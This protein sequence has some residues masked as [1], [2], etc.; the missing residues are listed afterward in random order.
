MKLINSNLLFLILSL[1]LLVE[2]KKP[3]PIYFG[4]LSGRV[5]DDANQELGIKCN[6]ILQPSGLSSTTDEN[7]Y[8]KFENLDPKDDFEVVVIFDGYN[9]FTEKITITSNQNTEL[10]V[11][12][13]S[14]PKLT[15]SS[16][17]VNEVISVGNTKSLTWSFNK[18]ENLKIEL[19]KADILVLT[20]ANTTDN[21]GIFEWTIPLNT[22]L[23]SGNDYKIKITSLVSSISVTSPLFTISL[24]EIKIST[25]A[26]TTIGN[27]LTI[28]WKYEITDDVK[29][30]LITGSNT[31]YLVVDRINNQ[32]TYNWKISLDKNIP[33]GPNNYIKIT[34]LNNPAISATSPLFTLALPEIKISSI[35]NSILGNNLKINWEYAMSDYVKIELVTGENTNFLIVDRMSNQLTH[36]WS[37][38]IDKNIPVGSGNYIKITSLSNPQIS[39]TSALFTLA[40][41]E[42]K[43]ASVS[44]TTLG[45]NVNISWNYDLSE[46]VKIELITGNNTTFVVA[47]RISNSKSYL[48]KIPLDKNLPSGGNN[49]FKIT[50]LSNTKIV[51]TSALFQIT[52]PTITI[53]SPVS[54]DVYLVESSKRIQWQY[55]N[56]EK[57]K[58]EL[59]HDTTFVSTISNE[60]DNLGEYLWKIPL[61]QKLPTSHLYRIK[62]SS[63]LDPKIFSI[64]PNF[65]IE[66]PQITINSPYANTVWDLGGTYNVT[67][68]YTPLDQLKV[69]LLSPTSTIVS[70]IVENNGTT[71]ISIPFPLGVPD[72]NNFSVKITSQTD[73]RIS[74]IINGITLKSPQISITSPVNAE[75]WNTD[76]EYNVSWQY[77]VNENVKIELLKGSTLV[78]VLAATIQNSGNTKV[79][80][81]YQTGFVAAN[82]Y[83][84]R[85]A[86]ITHPEIAS[87]SAPF[88]INVPQ[89]S[90]LSPVSNGNVIVGTNQ[91]ISWNY[92]SSNNVKIDLY[93]GGVWKKTITTSTPNTGSF[94]WAV[95]KDLQLLP[96][97]D[98]KI[99]ITN[100]NFT[101]IYAESSNFN[102]SILP[103]SASFTQN[104]KFARIIDEITFTNTSTNAHSYEWS[105]SAGHTSTLTSP[106]FTFNSIGTYTITLKS[107]TYD[108]QESVYQ[109]NI[110]IGNVY[111]TKITLTSIEWQIYGT[112]WD[113]VFGNCDGPDLKLYFGRAS[114]T[115]YEYSTGEWSNAVSNDITGGGVFPTFAT[116]LK[117]NNE[118]WK[119][120][121][122]DIDGIG[123]E[124]MFMLSA[125]FYNL[126]TFDA[127]TG[128]GTANFYL[129]ANNNYKWRMEYEILNQ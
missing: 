123:S 77:A 56:Y 5:V 63:T 68:T 22:S 16:P 119:M 94:S 81:P 3:D 128:K 48:W 35:P 26:N 37:I 100:E 126:F 115:G 113:C 116:K 104:T 23:L 30:E 21:D 51:G 52:Y 67:W 127:Q 57:L 106:V 6:V 43:F 33:T 24:P 87:E 45:S 11:R 120:E 105:T 84:I 40:L 53:L 108:G 19:F 118:T 98:Y 117:M 17:V 71:P 28:N 75:T 109:S 61:S 14:L 99:R 18:K 10:L 25:I 60:T 44:N 54:N 69:E 114:Q 41:P 4:T 15:I 8:F 49:Y 107:K 7:G 122:K 70:K 91:D 97:A 42:I 86:G 125:N 34:S 64:S 79:T 112:G 36:T 38:P 47:D 90:I 58:I 29:I 27:D 39:S 50:S 55:G 80:V 96:A 93:K 85:I 32:Q 65:R 124:S 110:T 103:P 74:T 9:E 92:V 66:L 95:T 111:L 101:E 2:C 13:V 78:R 129:N 46:D 62:I 83:K 72:G 82:D 102:I 31:S 121:L 12:L 59:Y 89:I 1:L 73:S 76:K 20:L 88:V